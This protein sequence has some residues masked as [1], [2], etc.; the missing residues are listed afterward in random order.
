MSAKQ[1]LPLSGLRI[2]DLSGEITGPY[3]TKLL[4]DAGADV[5]K[6]EPP[7]GDPLR[8]WSASHRSFAE[9]ESGALF[10]FLNASKRGAVADLET[11]D[12]RRLFLELAASVDVVVESE[13]PGRLDELGIGWETLH[14]LHPGLSLVSISPW[15]GTGPDAARPATEWTLQAAT[16]A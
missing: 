16:G 2:L 12:G 15:G 5:I 4:V 3:A 8:R 6:L 14:D 1:E 9:G 11:P 13:G 7:D 10:A